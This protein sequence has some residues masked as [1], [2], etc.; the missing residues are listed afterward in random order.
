M[1]MLKI[2]FIAIAVIFISGVC[3][4]DNGTDTR[5]IRTARGIV[6]SRDWI[7]SIIVVNYIRFFIPSD[8]KV[9]KGNSTIGFTGINLSDPVV[10]KYYQDSSGTY[11][12]VEIT[13]EYYGDFPV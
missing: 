12:A 13:V 4:C 11:R 3:Y 10:V 8:I 6:T 2:L 7:K 5:E 9:Y 1:K